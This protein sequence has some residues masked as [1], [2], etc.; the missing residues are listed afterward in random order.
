VNIITK[1]VHTVSIIPQS[2]ALVV[3]DMQ[4]AFLEPGTPLYIETPSEILDGIKELLNECRKSG[5]TVVFTRVYH[6]DIDQG[7][8]PDLFPDHFVN[9][10]PILVRNSEIFEIIPALR[11]R[12]DDIIIDKP[13]YSAFYKTNLDDILKSKRI[14]TLIIVGLAT[15]VCC[16]STARDAFFRDYKVLFIS[17][18]NVTYDKA[19]HEASLRTISDCFGYVMTKD[20]LLQ[21]LRKPL[22]QIR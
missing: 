22:M 19:L 3:V 21:L 6:D 1:N 15:N 11:P 5:M 7:I 8:Y 9:G 16:E 13:R 4:K 2:T 10:R 17:D 20:Q 14:D 18:L 12:D